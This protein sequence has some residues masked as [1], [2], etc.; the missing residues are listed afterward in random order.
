MSASHK[1]SELMEPKN[2]KISGRYL[3]LGVKVSQYVES[4]LNVLKLFKIY[5][6]I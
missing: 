4:I 5:N 3:K 6:I 1:T 2:V